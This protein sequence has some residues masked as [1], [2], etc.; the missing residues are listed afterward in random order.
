MKE[1]VAV[2]LVIAAAAAF[3]VFTTPAQNVLC[4]LGFAF[5]QVLSANHIV[6]LALLP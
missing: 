6:G 1:L 4:A 3:L 2:L 5:T